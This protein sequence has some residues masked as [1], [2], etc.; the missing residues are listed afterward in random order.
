MTTLPVKLGSGWIVVRSA[1]ADTS[2]PSAGTRVTPAFRNQM[3][4]ILG[5]QVPSA[6]V[7]RNVMVGANSTVF[8]SDNYYAAAVAEVKFKDYLNDDV[9]L[10]ASSPYIA[11]ATDGIVIGAL[12]IA[13]LPW[14]S[15]EMIAVA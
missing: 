8:P 7:R 3:Y 5:R 1:A 15:N 11:A 9:R 4:R 12:T 6:V 14:A 10:D 13:P 2:L